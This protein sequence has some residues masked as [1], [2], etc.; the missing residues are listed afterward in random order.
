MD[1]AESKVRGI[2][3]SVLLA[4]L[5]VMASALSALALDI[6][7]TV[8]Y[9]GS[10]TGRV[11]LSVYR[12]D[13]NSTGIGTSIAAPG[14]YTIRGVQDGTYVVKAFM[15][16]LGYGVPNTVDP[17]GQSSPVTISGAG[18]TGIVVTLADTSPTVPPP[19][20][21]GVMVTPGDNS[22]LVMWEG[23]KD[24][25]EFEAAQSYNLYWSTDSNVLGTW[26]TSGGR[27]TGIAARANEHQFLPFSNGS[28]Y[29]FAVTSL[30]GATESITAAASTQVTIGNPAGG[31]TVSGT[32]SF[33]GTPPGGPLVVGV[34]PPNGGPVAYTVIPSPVFPQSFTV[35]GVPAG[36]YTVFAFIDANGSN[37]LDLADPKT[38]RTS[39]PMIL[40]S[41]APLAGVAIQL[42][43]AGASIG[44]GTTHG[45]SSGG[46]EW[47]N[48]DFRVSNL[49]KLPVKVVLNSGP[50]LSSTPLPLDLG[51]DRWGEYQYT[52]Y[53]P[54]PNI[55]D[56]YN[57]SVTYSDATSETLLSQVTAVLDSFVNPQTP[58]GD[59]Y[60]PAV[61][62]PQFSWSA[63][64]SPP[65]AFTYGLYLNQQYNWIWNVDMMP[66]TQLSVNYNNDGQASQPSLSLG[67]TYSW[68]SVLRDAAGNQTQNEVTFTP[69]STTVPTG[70]AGG[71]F[72]YDSGTGALL[73]NW[74]SSAFPCDG[75]SIGTEIQTV[76]LLTDTTLTWTNGTDG[77]T[78]TRIAGTTGIVG[79]WRATDPSSGNTYTLTFNGNGTMSAVGDIYQCS[80][81]APQI[82]GFSPATGPVGSMVVIT[83][84]NFNS[85][86]ASNTVKFNGTVARVVSANTSQ[87]TVVVLAGST[88]GPV[89]VTTQSGIATS[90]SGFTVGTGSG[91]ADGTYSYSAGQL[92]LNWSNVNFP[93]DGPQTGTE[94]VTT[95]DATTMVWNNGMIWTRAP[96]TPGNIVDT[97]TAT[98][99]STGSSY[100]L[101]FNNDGTMTASGTIV[102]CNGDFQPPTIPGN[103]TAQAVG[104]NQINV[105]WSPSTDNNGVSYYQVYRNGQPAG[106]PGGQNNT[107]WP[108]TFVSPTTTYTYTVAACDFNGNCSAQSAS[109][110]ATTPAIPYSMIYGG[111]THLANS[112]TYGTPVDA[113]QIGIGKVGSSLGSMTATVSGPNGFSYTFSD[114]D[115][116]PYLN[117]QFEVYKEFTSPLDTG[118]YTFTLNDGSGTISNRVD[119]HVT[120]VNLP[121]VDSATIQMLR[122]S[123]GSYRFTWA[124]VNDTKTYFYSL[125][126]NK[127]DGTHTPV[128][129]G[130]RKMDGY[131][132]VP[133]GTLTDGVAYEVR[134]RVCDGPDFSLTFNQ[135][136]SAYVS[137]TPQSSDYNANRLMFNYAS[138]NNVSSD[139]PTFGFRMCTAAPS[140]TCG[141]TQANQVTSFTLTGPS[142]FSYTNSTPSTEL[143]SPN[144]VDFAHKVPSA[145]TGSYMLDVTANGIHHY[146]YVTLTPAVSYP[147]PSLSNYKAEYINNNADPTIRFSWADADQTGAL[148]YR[149][150][151]KASNN[152][153]DYTSSQRTNQTYVDIAKSLLGDLTFKQWRVEVYD[154]SSA[155]TQ[156]NRINGTF[157]A[158]GSLNSLPAYVGNKPAIGQFRFRNLLHPGGSATDISIGASDDT[159]PLG[160][161]LVNGPGSYSR[162][163]LLGT[164]GWTGTGPYSYSYSMVEA[165]APAAGLYSLSVTDGSANSVTRYNQQ[166]TFHDVPLVDFRTFKVSLDANGD[167]RFSWAPVVTDVPVWYSLEL[168]AVNTM[169]SIS[170]TGLNNVQQA[171]VT[172]PA[173][174]MQSASLQGPLMFRV[175]VNDG[176]GWSTSN[177]A[178]QS[179]YAGYSVNF[180]YAT[181]TDNDGDGFA[182]NVD[183]NDGDPT[184]NPY[185]AAGGTYSIVGR[186]T[187]QAS[188]PLAGVLVMV[189]NGSTLDFV[190]SATTDSSGYYAVTG[191]PAGSYK[192]QFID[193]SLTYDGIWYNGKHDGTAADAI[194]FYGPALTTFTA[195][196]ALTTGQTGGISGRVTDGVNGI[197]GIRVGAFRASNMAYAAGAITDANGFFVIGGLTTDNYK[198]IFVG[199]DAGFQDLWY[200]G[201][202]TPDAA[203]S[204]SVTAPN[205]T[206]NVN[207]ALVRSTTTT[208]VLASGGNPSYAGDPLTFTATVSPVPSGGTVQFKV[209]GVNVGSPV[210]LVGGSAT[211]AAVTS[212]LPGVHTV[213]AEY[214]GGTG[215]AAS[216]SSG[217]SQTAN[218]KTVI[219]SNG[220]FLS[221]QAA[222]SASLNSDILLLRDAR[223]AED[224]LINAT[225]TRPASFTITIKGGL[226]SDFTTPAA[227]FSSVRKLTIKDGKVIVSRLA[228]KP[229]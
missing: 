74:T 65:A 97:W 21:N 191:L 81:P 36:S 138:A 186:V 30:I 4:V 50:N 135:A 179:A 165:G 82:S 227:T 64:D 160:S 203:A 25:N 44:A 103:V 221:L 69:R 51:I 140:P 52:I 147:T 22:A 154:S 18:Q 113:L 79:T 143:I 5:L 9:G 31:T 166:P 80:N 134:V 229:D 106:T 46:S 131:E 204:V 155:N 208:V 19:A 146:A 211:S 129:N 123:D 96:G 201:A 193:P 101:T 175:R 206:S 3:L 156:R 124:P 176:S 45:R 181:L 112:D 39:E 149:V 226:G 15:D 53:T 178:S 11:Y 144:L 91:S 199:S 169:T 190:N 32:V 114:A 184:I 151:V 172:I 157:T 54:R 198:V 59:I 223:F 205:Y 225:V 61:T 93:C 130:L 194:T 60:G 75:P 83:G 170:T 185:A 37:T 121:A 182:S 99:P 17:L 1:R 78:W 119:T 215:Y 115:V 152:S 167:S 7:G 187:D 202:A 228:V 28:K 100:V 40:V 38:S 108:D 88:S 200:N 174:T 126:I 212:M 23:P 162:N 102:Q 73:L 142:G 189:L 70:S 63:P 195:N 12:Q 224:L 62:T 197:A 180:D 27:V 66:M 168:V 161:A 105:N 216:I 43:N 188:A 84:S 148:Y 177:N 110:Q 117:G 107:F 34:N 109:A 210:A 41:G 47:F 6:S 209:D 86:P 125:R 218:P 220:N 58:V 72:T 136:N 145:A 111:V 173:A 98:D 118:V 71:T 56:T 214:S 90:A 14:A 127:A 183:P 10:K 13:G 8:S 219:G 68:T 92:T 48:I 196:A 76:T 158:S 29:Y 77:M 42:N 89:T 2:G 122:K 128:F 24:N 16:T 49:K 192:V 26:G 171:S 222:I 67:T 137:F 55:G 213:T 163:L 139:S 20:P 57:F 217:I 116:R 132:D 35:S 153:S 207:G 94:T 164:G 85:N 120:P 159:S 33:S 104:P 133:V 87:L 150:F 141:Q 95:L